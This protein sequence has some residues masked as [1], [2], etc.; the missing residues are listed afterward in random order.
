MS[1]YIP[2]GFA[3]GFCALENNTIVHYKCTKYRNAESEVG[4]NWNDPDL[5]IK[6]PIKKPI[7]SSK[8]KYNLSLKEYKIIFKIWIYEK[9]IFRFIQTIITNSYLK[10]VNS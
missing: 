1:F 7:I 4:I 3:H 9:S 2:P 8:D 6:W 5:N 10:N